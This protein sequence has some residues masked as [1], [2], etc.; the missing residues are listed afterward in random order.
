MADGYAAK[1]EYPLHT[2]S[3]SY[4]LKRFDALYTKYLADSDSRIYMTVIPDKGYYLAQQNGYPAMDYT[5]LT[6]QLTAGMP[7]AT[8][9]DLT[10]TLDIGDYYRTDT[11]W[12]QEKLID[13]AN[14][15][16]QAMDLHRVF[17]C[18]LNLGIEY[19]FQ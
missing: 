18:I 9:I 19:S 6:E 14:A 13:T 12:R 3:V 7:W 17:H 10:A 15:I 8:P 11:H 2:T 4:A 5:A 1:L 16:C